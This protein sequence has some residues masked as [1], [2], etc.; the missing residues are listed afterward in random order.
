[1]FYCELNVVSASVTNVGERCCH[2]IHTMLSEHCL[3][4]GHPWWGPTLPQRSHNV[5]WTSSQCRSPMLG[6]KL[7]TMFTQCCLNVVS[8]WVTNAGDQ[9]HHNCHITLPQSCYNVRQHWYNIATMFT[10][11]FG[12]VHLQCCSNGVK[13]LH[14][15]VVTTFGSN[16]A[17]MFAQRCDNVGVLAGKGCILHRNPLA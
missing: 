14:I 3:K 7:A 13:C 1:M 12:N 8:M 9:C 10:Q 5:A 2:N 17:T 4:V 11:R 15:N 16:V 6:T